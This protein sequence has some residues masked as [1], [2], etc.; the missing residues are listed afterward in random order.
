MVSNRLMHAFRLSVLLLSFLAY[1]LLIE[2]Q[3]SVQPEC[4]SKLVAKR[5]KTPRLASMGIVNGLALKL[6]KPPYPLAAAAVNV[7]GEVRVAVLL[8]QGGCVVTAEIQSGHPLLRKSSIDAAKASTFGPLIFDTS[9]VQIWGLIVYR[10]Q[11]MRANWLEFGYSADDFEYVATYL[12]AELET[13]RLLLD[14]SRNGGADEKKIILA[15]VHS[16]VAAHLKLD[17]KSQWLF[18]LGRCLRNDE[19]TSWGNRREEFVSDLRYRLSQAPPGVSEHLTKV[20]TDLTALT[21][22][23]EISSKTRFLLDQL[24][25]LGN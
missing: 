23:K 15:N 3:S 20:L 6:V 11:P 22:W 18:E 13:Q 17:P 24:H 25:Q 5:H 14:Q 10:F 16:A 12:P 9:P 8:D 2:A 1:N 7:A 4:P 19:P 21:D